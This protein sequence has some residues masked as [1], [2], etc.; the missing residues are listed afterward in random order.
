MIRMFQRVKALAKKLK[1]SPE[2]ADNIRFPC[3]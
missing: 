1:M 2:Q 3:C